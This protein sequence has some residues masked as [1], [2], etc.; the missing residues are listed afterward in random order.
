MDRDEIDRTL[1][2]L[3]GERERITKVLLE[4]EAHQGYQM[5]K[6]TPL[7]GAT[8]RYWIDIDGRMATLWKLFDAYGKVLDEAE[9]LR[10]RHPKPGQVQLA[11]LTR[12]L[13]GTSVELVSGEIPLEERTLLGPTGEWLSL[14]G[15]VQRMTPMYEQTAGM[16]ATVDEVWSA[17]L[18]RLGEVEEAARAV[19]ALHASL[20][21]REPDAERISG[22]LPGVREAV[23]ADPLSLSSGGRAD[24]RRIEE[25]GRE[26]AAQRGRLEDAVRIRD[27]HDERVRGIE[28]T[29]ALVEAAEH[30]AVTAQDQVLAKIASPALPELPVLAAP[31]RDRLAAL[32]GLRGDG[33]WLEL[34]TRAAELEQAAA[35][36]LE[37]ARQTTGLITGLLD[38]R[39]ELR[40]RLD[41]YQAKAGRLGLAE[42]TDLTD[43]HQRAHDLLWTSPCDLRQATVTLADYQRAI[44]SHT[45]GTRS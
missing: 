45:E 13:T 29:I 10:A 37:R 24:T 28:A 5:L 38:R 25:I 42:E 15:V 19:Q 11:E 16:V 4:L 18:T 3:K 14:D 17:L 22:Q 36:A 31:L 20:G 8:Q 27:E 21:V 30:E 26:L 39:D 43:L 40:G 33:R 1:R 7:T 6:G 23:R 12:L 44:A 9:E 34:A 35:T 32:G 41:A 2:R